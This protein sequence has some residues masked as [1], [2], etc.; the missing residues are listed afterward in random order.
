MVSHPIIQPKDH[1]LVRALCAVLLAA[2][3]AAHALEPQSFISSWGAALMPRTGKGAI[4]AD[5]FRQVTLRQTVRLS[6]G[7]SALRVRISNLHGKEALVI[8]A[9]TLGTAAMPGRDQLGARP[10]K[11]LLFDG[12]SKVVVPAGTEKTSDALDWAAPRG[13]D[14]AISIYVE[15][16]PAQQSVHLAAHSTQFIAPGDQTG[17]I[18]LVGARPLTSWFQLGGVEVQPAARAGVLVAIGDSITDGSGSTRD[19]NE[20]WTD[21]LARR[22]QREHGPQLAVINAGIGGNRMLHDDIGPQ[23]LARFDHDVLDRPGVTHALVLIGVN[24]LGRLHRSTTETA[25]TR[26]AMLNDLQAGWRELVRKAHARGVCVIAGT[27]TPYG[28]STLYNPAPF[29]EAD[30]QSMN[31]WLRTADNI[32]GVADFDA[33]VRDPSTPERLRAEFDSGDHLHL[34]PAGYGA[35]AAAVP[36]GLLAACHPSSPAK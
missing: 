26:Q 29:N 24:D 3:P 20:R 34:S 19:Q 4:P 30:R 13:D 10:V 23:L 28:A 1:S 9:A 8:G 7:G 11:A 31:A 5:E 2:I 15:S 32:D 33:A 18:E 21:F 14:V 27:M 36:V 25:E 35:M 17:R 16:G 12:A 22:L 6:L